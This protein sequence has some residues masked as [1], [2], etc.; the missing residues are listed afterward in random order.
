MPYVLI[1]GLIGEILLN[2]LHK[3]YVSWLLPLF[4]CLII[5]WLLA[6][7][8]V[9]GLW[10]ILIGTVLN[11]VV[12]LLNH[13]SMPVLEQTMRMLHMSVS[14]HIGSR[15]SIIANPRGD[16]WLG[17]WLPIPPYI[18]SPGDI[19]VGLGIVWFALSNTRKRATPV[20]TTSSNKL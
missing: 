12:I 4:L 8:H 5:V 19:L 17:D 6:N 14:D 10:L 2:L 20:G 18:M 16:W 3:S 1:F 11:I 13:G 9:K 15:H 7:I